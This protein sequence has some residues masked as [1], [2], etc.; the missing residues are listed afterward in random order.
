MARIKPLMALDPNARSTGRYTIRSLY[1][2]DLQNSCFFENEDGVDQRS[3]FRI[4]IYNHNSGEIRLEQKEKLRGK[5][6]KHGCDISLEQCKLLM[7]GIPPNEK[8]QPFLLQKLCVLMR[9]RLMRPKVIVEYERIPYVH[10]LGNVRITF[11]YN[12]R[13]SCDISSFLSEDIPNRPFMP[14]GQHLL[15]VKFDQFLPD[16]IARQAQLDMLQLTN[17]SKYYQCMK[18]RLGGSSL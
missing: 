1:F 6:L 8:D 17:Y 5:T 18:Y 14:Q 9:T 13:S 10:A 3:K 15:E 2:D 4:R 16:A 7:R 11:D 12:I